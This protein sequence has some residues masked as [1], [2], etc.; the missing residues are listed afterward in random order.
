MLHVIQWNFNGGTLKEC[1]YLYLIIDEKC[2]ILFLSFGQFY[3]AN[4]IWNLFIK[5]N[6]NFGHECLENQ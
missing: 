3:V 1:L 5:K 6:V 2:M 4:L